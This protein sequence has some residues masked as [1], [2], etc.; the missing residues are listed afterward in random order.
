[1]H[2]AI[3]DIDLVTSRGMRP[4][5][6]IFVTG[7]QSSKETLTRDDKTALRQA[8]SG[9]S[10]LRLVVHG[11]Y[12]DNPWSSAS[13]YSVDNICAEMKIAAELGATGVIVHLSNSTNTG[14]DAVLTALSRGLAELVGVGSPILWLEIHAAKATA[15]SFETPAKLAALFARVAQLRAAMPLPTIGLCIDS[16]HLHACGTNLRDYAPT[17][18][19]LQAMAV[20]DAP[21]MVHLNDS[22]SKLGSGIDKHAALCTGTIWGE[23]GDD[24][25]LPIEDSGLMAILD[26]ADEVSAT[27]VLER[28]GDVTGDLD[29]IA[30]LGYMRA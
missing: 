1:M 19:W 27:V 26:W 29:L 24:G 2:E 28:D 5:A 30:R 12:I 4:C 15:N 16:A 17:W 10:P 7:P 25:R 22:M 13:A 23:F 8:T 9:D 11:A 3:K 14:L 18:E 20:G 6:Q 21:V